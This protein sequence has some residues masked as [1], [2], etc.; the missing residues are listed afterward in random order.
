M[1]RKRRLHAP[2]SV[3]FRSTA[4]VSDPVLGQPAYLRLAIHEGENECAGILRIRVWGIDL[5][6]P[7][8]KTS[9]GHPASHLLKQPM[10]AKIQVRR[11]WDENRER[12]KN[13][14]T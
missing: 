13:G 11:I 14:I 8:V 12:S 1:L 2:Y 4:S 9:R 3:A 7:T 5:A 10:P 6:I